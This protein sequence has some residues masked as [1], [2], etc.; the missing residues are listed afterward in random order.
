MSDAVVVVMTGLPGSGKTTLGRALAAEL[1]LPFLDKDDI[2]E[3]LFAQ[4]PVDGPQDR[5]RLSRASD[6]V[7]ES[8]ATGI[9]SAV[10]ASFWRREELSRTSGTPT[11]WLRD[12]PGSLVEVQC[13]CPPD[14]AA[15]RFVERQRHLSHLDADRSVDDLAA[16]LSQLDALGPWGLGAL[17]TVDTGASYDVVE[18]AGRVRSLLPVGD[19]P[20]ASG[21]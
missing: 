14:V 8:V 20:I 19:R 5:Q 3:T 1:G 13:V 17:L 10:L 18:V 4:F 12:L 11:A 21:A 6:A 2:L 16:Q 7:L 15:R 9:G